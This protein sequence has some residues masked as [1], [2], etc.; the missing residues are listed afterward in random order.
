MFTVAVPSAGDRW[1]VDICLMLV[2]SK[3][4]S[5]NPSEMS[6]GGAENAGAGVDTVD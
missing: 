4:R 1:V 5:T 2:T 3:P 6:S